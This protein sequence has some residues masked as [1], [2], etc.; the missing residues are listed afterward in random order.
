MKNLVLL[1]VI[2]ISL[3]MC[4][5]P[6][7]AQHM[8]PPYE[9][10]NFKAQCLNSLKDDVSLQSAFTYNMLREICNCA[11]DQ[12]ELKYDWDSFAQIS[13]PPLSKEAEEQ[14]FNT[15]YACALQTLHKFKV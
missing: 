15:S 14:F 1:L 6:S 5:T 13:A 9:K 7:P 3:T 2:A 10:Q 4:S 8:W 12:W 11:A